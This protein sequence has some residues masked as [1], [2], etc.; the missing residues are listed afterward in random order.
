MKRDKSVF[1]FKQFEVKHTATAL[2]VTTDAVVFG[3]WIDFSGA[4]TILDIGTGTGILALMAAQK[5]AA[6][7]ISAIE[8]DTNA[9][10]EADFNFSSSKWSERLFVTNCDIK[11][12]ISE[13]LFD[14]IVSNPPYFQNDLISESKAKAVAKH[15][16]S[17][18]HKQLLEKTAT[19]LNDSGTAFFILPYSNSSQFIVTALN[20]GLHCAKK[21]DVS[22]TITKW[23]YLSF[24]AFT[25]L[26]NDLQANQLYLFEHNGDK[27][28]D[29]Q[30]MSADFYL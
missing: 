4:K 27:S 25:K 20:C 24:L 10:K 7:K 18:T 14:I 22:S 30:A 12:Y 16:I 19:L 11:E 13:E 1:R 17:L 29:Y 28:I 23:P 2:K 9:A 8:I 15:A 21:V 6:A 26:T 5:N 3:S